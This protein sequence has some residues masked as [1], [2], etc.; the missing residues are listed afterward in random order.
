MASVLLGVL[1]LSSEITNNVNPTKATY[2]KLLRTS[3]E[4]I[5]DSLHLDQKGLSRR[6]YYCAINSFVELKSEGL[7][8][9]DSILTVVD[10]DQPSYKKRMYIINLK[11]KKLLFNTWTAH[12]KNTGTV[13]AK[14]FSNKIGSLQSSL[15]MY[16]TDKS[17][18]GS[19]G[20]SLRLIGLDE[21]NF[22]AEER[23]IVLH[24]ADYV[25]QQNINEAGYIGRS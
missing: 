9:N 10:F 2:K 17:Y 13:L 22:N 24:G 6:G 12:G 8:S 19:N 3:I 15:G 5:F 7:L 21:T 25:S 1:S 20:Y 14:Y 23:S 18:I 4:S 11:S 16:V